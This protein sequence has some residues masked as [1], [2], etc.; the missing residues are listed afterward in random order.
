MP[1]DVR[2]FAAKNPDLTSKVCALIEFEKTEFAIRARK[3]LNCEKVDQMKVSWL[4][5]A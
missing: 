4:K 2:P 5:I 1:A 3:T